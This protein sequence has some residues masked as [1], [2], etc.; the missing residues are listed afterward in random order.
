[1][2]AEAL[3]LLPALAVLV[4]LFAWPQGAMLAGASGF[5]RLLDPYWLGVFGRSLALGACVTAIT[6]VLGIPLAWL[7]ARG[8]GR[9]AP[10]LLLV[11]TFPLWVSAVV[12]AFGWVVLLARGGVVA[13]GLMALGLSR[14]NA[15]LLYTFAGVTVALAQVLLPFMVLTLYGVF[16]GIDP[17]LEEAARNLGASQGAAFGLVTLP[18]ARGGV[19][20]GALLVFALAIGAFA[21]P[22]LVGGA[23]AQVV[24][25]SILEQTLELL[26]WGFAAALST[27][28]LVAVLVLVLLAGRIGRT[29]SA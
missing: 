10:A 16:R 25:T 7:L 26:D 12:R 14:V 21:T 4:L 27:V 9:W 28:L 18:L 3:L 13:Q 23:R 20:G 17:R 24:S 19:V 2:R 11:T 22:S 5:G 6:L 1:M 8:T 29:A 15:T